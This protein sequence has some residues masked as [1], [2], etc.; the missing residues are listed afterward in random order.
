MHLGKVMMAGNRKIVSVVMDGDLSS[1]A[2]TAEDS[3][4]THIF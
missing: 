4:E 2:S 3:H 1:L